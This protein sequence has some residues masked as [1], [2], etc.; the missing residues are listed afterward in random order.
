M[1][2]TLN[3]PDI[4]CAHCKSTIEGAVAPLEGVSSVEVDIDGRTVEVD[5]DP[6]QTD[7]DKITAAI[8]EVG[9]EVA[10]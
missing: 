10:G 2:V 5:F 4:S 3:V 9:Y 1:P 6:S 8:E 7:L